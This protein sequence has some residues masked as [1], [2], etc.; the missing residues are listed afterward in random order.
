MT[1]DFK[2]YPTSIAEVKANGARDARLWGARDVLINCL[3]EIDEG[4]VAPTTLVICVAL[5]G[6]RP[7][8]V[9]TRFWQCGPNLHVALGLLERVKTLMQ[10]PD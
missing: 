1:D 7:G 8:M 5:E 10:E 3:R 6:D 2:G 4:T 9:A